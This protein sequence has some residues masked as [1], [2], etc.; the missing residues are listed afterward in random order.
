MASKTS[1]NTELKDPKTGAVRVV[2]NE[3]VKKYEDRGWEK[4]SKSSKSSSD[5]S[6]SK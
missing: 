4:T 2:P 3:L 1:V 6:S 5:S